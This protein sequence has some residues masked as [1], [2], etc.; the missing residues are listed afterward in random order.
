MVAKTDAIAAV[1][2]AI[3][4]GF[5]GAATRL[6]GGSKSDVT[7]VIPSGVEVLDKYVLGPGGWPVGRISEVFSQ[8][9]GGKTSLLLAALAGAQRVGG[10][11]VMVETETA[12]D[13]RRA[14]VFG[15]D[16]DR[17]VLLQPGHLGEALR[18]IELTLKS[19][20]AGV[21]P[22]MIG[23]DSVA[24]T[25]SVEEALEGLPEKAAFDKRAKA[26]S[27][28]MRV[29]GPLVARARAHLM[30]VNQTRANIG[31]LFG[32]KHVTPGGGAIKFHAAARVQLMGGKAFKD[33]IGQHLGKD[34][35]VIA[36]KNKLT[37]PYRKAR[38]RLN[39]DTGWDDAW[40]TLNHAKELKV[41]DARSRDVAAARAALEAVE[42]HRSASA[43]IASPG[44][45]V[46]TQDA[47]LDEEGL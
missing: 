40:S 45:D 36:V 5:K 17:V 31:V 30:L 21:G 37:R 46:D 11:A 23:W 15:V 25:Q 1:L 4:A 44:E 34:V 19:I 18:Q 39:Y 10:I 16:L 7:E 28:G 20:P 24:A 32:D 14:K 29:L 9:G 26:L 42:W 13:S 41:V 3:N 6:S 12:L 33:P 38:V 8:E 43:P 22:I 47:D 35:T 27:E 2:K